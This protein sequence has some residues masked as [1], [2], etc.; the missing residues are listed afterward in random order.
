MKFV[1]ASASPRRKEL[2]TSAGFEYEVHPAN[3][4]E[5]I[6]DGTPTESV[7]EVLAKQKAES[8]LKDYPDA[9]VLGSDTIVV[10]DGKILG[11]P[12]DKEDAANML[13]SLSGREHQVYTGLCVCSKDKTCCMT[14]C[15]DVYFHKLSDELVSAYI[16]TGEPMDKAGAY[17]A[18]GLGSVLVEKIN[19]DFFTVMGLPIADAVRILAKFG[20]VGTLPLENS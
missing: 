18:Q 4:D 9:V 6:P 10:L 1:L 12:H 11:K 2:L 3:I 8:V 13:H 7:A 5:I 17:G 19:G 15:T 16:E 14:S 20:I